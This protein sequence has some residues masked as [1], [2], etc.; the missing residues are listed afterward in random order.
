MS[1]RCYLADGRLKAL[2]GLVPGAPFE[3]VALTP[4]G[5]T[6]PAAELLIEALTANLLESDGPICH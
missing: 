3:L 6:L 5:G 4:R 1:I 2:E